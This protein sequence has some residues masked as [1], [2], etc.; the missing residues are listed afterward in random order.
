[1]KNSTLKNFKNKM[2]RG[3]AKG[4]LLFEMAEDI[5]DFISNAKLYKDLK[6]K[7]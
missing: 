3:K 6:K 4:I 5:V 2:V 7:K 1:M